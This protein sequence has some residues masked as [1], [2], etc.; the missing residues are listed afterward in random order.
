MLQQHS[1]NISYIFYFSLFCMWDT[2]SS[3]HILYTVVAS[4]CRSYQNPFTDLILSLSFEGGQVSPNLA[5]ACLPAEK[6]QI[7]GVS[8][9][10]YELSGSVRL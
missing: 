10:D 7:I 1:G 2:C 9:L 8:L 4:S 3:V 5:A 6:N